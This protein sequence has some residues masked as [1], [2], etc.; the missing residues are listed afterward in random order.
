MEDRNYFYVIRIGTEGV[1]FGALFHH[2]RDFACLLKHPVYIQ[3][4][5]QTN[6]IEKSNQ[7]N[8][9]HIDKNVE[10]HKKMKRA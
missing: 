6:T 5:C 10:L 3:I 4:Y 2:S 1:W 8:P 9:P 7:K